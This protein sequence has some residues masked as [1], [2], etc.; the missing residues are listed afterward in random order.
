MTY[1]VTQDIYFTNFLSSKPKLTEET[2]K[3]YKRILTKFTKSTGKTLEEIINSCK[4][5]QE[6]ITE[7]TIYRGEDEDGNTIVQ[8]Q[9]IRFDVNG[10]SSKVKQYLDQHIKYCHDKNNSNVTINS[11][12]TQIKAFLKFYD[13]TLPKMETLED[14]T[15]KWYL[16]TKEDFKYIINESPI[17]HA[18]LIKFLMSTGMR[19][20]DVTSLTIGDFMEATK[21]Y[22]DYTDVNDFIDNAPDG[23]IG[24]WNFH[25]SKTI[26]F[27][28]QCV[29]F[30]DPES[31]NLILQNL[32]KI[33]N[34]VNRPMSKTDALF[35][36]QKQDYHKSITAGSIAAEFWKKNQKLRKWR[37][38]KLREAID[39]GD[40]SGEDYEKEVNKIPRFHAHA[41]RKFFETTISR[42]CGDLRICTLMEGHVSPVATDSSYIKQEV[43]DVKE[44]YITAIP[45][46]SLENTEVKVYTSEIR[47]EMENKIHTLE[48]NVKEK[49]AEVQSMSE[50]MDSFEKRLREID[51]MEFSLEE[52]LK[53]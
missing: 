22:H 31:S 34:H 45:D 32:R 37:K 27:K 51:E 21:D 18:S 2:R 43:R 39:N 24:T 12:M 8:K 42:N 50:R 7:K 1:N 29:T 4:Q 40:L 44:H 23:M 5:Q 17:G 46:L 53:K 49:E 52:L 16:L 6:I 10:P 25:P 9:T 48:A 26:K 33:K 47:K 35:S 14:D 15:R 13:I 28:V 36:S 20:K 3:G 41:C 38:L 30:N 11:N 19:A